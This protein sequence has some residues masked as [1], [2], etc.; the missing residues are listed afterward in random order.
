[1]LEWLNNRGRTA[2]GIAVYDTKRDRL[3][4]R[5]GSGFPTEKD[6]IGVKG[7]IGVAHLRYST[8]GSNDPN[9]VPYNAQ[10]KVLE[11]IESNSHFSPEPCD[12]RKRRDMNVRN[13][14][15]VGANCDIFDTGERRDAHYECDVKYL[16]FPFADELCREY[17]G[18]IKPKKIVETAKKVVPKLDG[19]YTY[20]GFTVDGGGNALL[21]AGKDPWGIRP[22]FISWLDKPGF[23]GWLVASEDTALLTQDCMN[24]Q[25]IEHGSIYIMTDRLSNA[26]V[27]QQDPTHSFS[28][29]FEYVYFSNLGTTLNGT[30]VANFKYDAGLALGKECPPLDKNGKLIKNARVVPIPESGRSYARGY[31]DATGLFDFEGFSKNRHRSGRNFIL[32]TQRVRESDIKHILLPIRSIMENQ[33]IVLLEDS[34]V[35]G[36]T[37][38]RIV[39]MVRRVGGASEVHVRSGCPPLVAPCYLAI[40]MKSTNEFIATRVAEKKGYDPYD[41]SK[42]QLNEVVDGV[43]EE[44]GADSLGYLSM[45]SFQKILSPNHCF[46]CWNTKLNPPGL[47]EKIEGFIREHPEGYRV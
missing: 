7:N 41:L 18:K 29:A 32:Q 47:V 23:Q 5:K 6:V 15:A 36:T 26:L 10:P 27:K 42:E 28:C 11:L 22:G 14:L 12:Q 3:H 45:E 17:R 44:I 19:A 43:C 40:D 38:K 39:D 30:P 25:E 16:A 8:R 4:I 31:R 37:M 34:I 46:G 21:F 2:W 33:T 1:M 13:I 24:T 20:T 9:E 35:R